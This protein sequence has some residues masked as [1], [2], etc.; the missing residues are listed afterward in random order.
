M[1]VTC[2]A[3]FL[4][5][6]EIYFSTNKIFVQS[7]F[8]IFMTIDFLMLYRVDLETCC[9]LGRRDNRN[10]TASELTQ[11]ASFFVLHALEFL[12]SVYF[13]KIT[14]NFRMS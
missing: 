9:M 7:L 12:S 8:V 11:V 1:F 3:V 13:S 5:L 2:Q 6:V 4:E 10:I 14:E